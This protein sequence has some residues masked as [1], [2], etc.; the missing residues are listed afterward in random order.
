MTST[1]GTRI[2]ETWHDVVET[3]E[4]DEY[5]R[6]ALADP[7][8]VMDPTTVGRS[9]RVV[10][11]VD[12]H[13]RKA[14][15]RKVSE[16]I[17]LRRAS[18]RECVFWRTLHQRTITRTAAGMVVET[19]TTGGYSRTSTSLRLFATDTADAVQVVRGSLG[20]GRDY[21]ATGGQVTSVRRRLENTIG[22][23]PI[24]TE[25]FPLLASNDSSGFATTL[26][27]IA[28]ASAHIQDPWLDSIDAAQVARKLYG[29]RNYRRPMAREVARLDPYTL[30]WY[31]VF[32][33]LVPPDWI[34]DALRR[35]PDDHPSP[36][37]LSSTQ[38]KS[39]RALL[40][41]T[42]QPVL[43]RLLK[44][45]LGPLSMAMRDTADLMRSFA[46]RFRGDDDIA[47]LLALAGQRNIR[48]STDLHN[49][50]M[51]VP[52]NPELLLRNTA[53]AAATGKV[54]A[55]ER[56]LRYLLDRLNECRVEED[57]ELVEWQTWIGLTTDERAQLLNDLDQRELDAERLSVAGFVV[58]PTAAIVQVCMPPGHSRHI[59]L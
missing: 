38:V 27:T 26:S 29:A 11:L 44:E 41:R 2:I 57:L 46:V 48:S 50:V 37:G 18:G 51:T 36:Q 19:T 33:G 17:H 21:L 39:L 24:I 1:E 15:A 9:A 13:G 53:R 8:R 58:Y 47:R 31:A 23:A 45:P 49:L 32:R 34:V 5:A 3:H 42:P 28:T 56:E 22:P 54:M 10:L 59:Y 55:M 4:L 16:K 40:V 25:R 52:S 35:V 20:A 6:D 30:S 43:R 14:V 7:T 12:R